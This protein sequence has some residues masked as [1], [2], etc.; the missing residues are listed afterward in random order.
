MEIHLESRLIVLNSFIVADK[1]SVAAE[2][3]ISTISSISSGQLQ[4]FRVNDDDSY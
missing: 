1:L 4:V 3:E 2:F